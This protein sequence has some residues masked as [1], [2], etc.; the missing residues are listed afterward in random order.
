MYFYSS[1]K[2]FIQTTGYVSIGI[3]A[4]TPTTANGGTPG[5]GGHP[6]TAPSPT[7]FHGTCN[8]QATAAEVYTTGCLQSLIP[9]N[10]LILPQYSYDCKCIV[11]KVDL[12]RLR[13]SSNG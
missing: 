2:S 12:S 1:K 13:H 7:S 3:G 11:I 6:P 5:G 10:S 9:S 4:G 8:G